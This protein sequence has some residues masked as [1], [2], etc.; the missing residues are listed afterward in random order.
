M[1]IVQSPNEE[2]FKCAHCDR[3]FAKWNCSTKH[4]TVSHKNNQRFFNRARCVRRLT[5]KTKKDRHEARCRNRRHEYY[6]CKKYLLNRLANMQ[7]PVRTHVDE[8]SFK[9]NIRKKHF[10]HPNTLRRHIVSCTQ[11]IIIMI[12]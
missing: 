7:E 6:L 11:E 9:C 4:F 8:K 2:P 3:R 10:Q 12:L 1:D 5:Q